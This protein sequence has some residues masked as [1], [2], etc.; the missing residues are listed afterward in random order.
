MVDHDTWGNESTVDGELDGSSH[1][2]SADFL[3]G[4]IN[5]HNAIGDH[6]NSKNSCKGMNL[7]VTIS[8]T[9]R[10]SINSS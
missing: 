1:K 4:Q 6:S 9:N 7:Y 3:E 2:V 5:L 10:L 8:I